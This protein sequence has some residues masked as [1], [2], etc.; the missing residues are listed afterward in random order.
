MR[1]H[2][3]S[4]ALAG[5]LLLAV[6]CGKEVGRIPLAGEGDGDTAVTLK[7]GQHL[8]L[9]THLD[10]SWDGPFAAHYDVELRDAS[11]KAV[12]TA[13]CNPLD[14]GTKIGSVETTLGSHHSKS[15]N[16]KMRCELV[17]PAAGKYTVHTA[18]H[19]DTKPRTL[20]VKDASLVLKL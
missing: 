14:V 9:W 19:Y 8:A 13:T 7:S 6:G 5:S 16:G 18:L 1:R 2:S 12:A 11:S 20:T 15:Y 3:L 10:V 4:L 17:A